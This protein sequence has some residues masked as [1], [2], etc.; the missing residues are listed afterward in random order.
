MSELSQARTAKEHLRA[1]LHDQDDVVGV[2]LTR[3]G[4]GSDADYCIK[5]NVC[6]DEA[7]QQVPRTFEGVEVQVVVVGH[8]H[9]F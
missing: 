9:K 6:D 1:R 3:S 2:G 4:T 5:V 7:A 8:I